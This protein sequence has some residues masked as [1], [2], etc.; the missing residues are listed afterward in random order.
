MG[1]WPIFSVSLTFTS[2]TRTLNLCWGLTTV[3]CSRIFGEKFTEVTNRC[4]YLFYCTNVTSAEILSFQLIRLQDSFVTCIS[5]WN[6]WITMILCK[7]RDSQKWKKISTKFVIGCG[8]QRLLKSCSVTENSIAW[9]IK[10]KEE[11]FHAFCIHNFSQ[12]VLMSN[13]I[14]VFV[15]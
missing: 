5:W 3:V 10:W 2:L 7:K 8:A 15:D 4:W 13:L 1:S 11:T 14:A 6:D 9:K 12:Q